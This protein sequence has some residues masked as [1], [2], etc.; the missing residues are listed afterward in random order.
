MKIKRICCVLI[1]ALLLMSVFPAVASAENGMPQHIPRIVS[2]VFDDSGSMYA[3]VSRWA[4]CSYAMQSFCAMMDETDELYV[5]Y[6][7]GRSDTQTVRLNKSTKQAEIDKFASLPFGGG[8]P[9]KVQAAADVLTDRYRRYGSEAKYF[10]LV[11]ADGELDDKT[12]TLRAEISKTAALTTQTIPASEFT[13]EFFDMS[14]YGGENA[15]ASES[16][17]SEKLRNICA[18]ITGRD[19]VDFRLDNGK[20]TFSIPYPAFSIVVFAQTYGSTISAGSVSAK[21]PD[22]KNVSGISSFSVK[23]PTQINRRPDFQEAVPDNP[24]SGVVSILKNGSAPLAKGSYTV[25]LSAAGLKKENVVVLIEPAVCIG[26]KYFIGEDK[27]PYTFEEASGKLSVGDQLTVQ[28][29]LYE[30]N[31]DGSIG[32]EVPEN[33]LKCDYSAYINGEQLNSARSSLKNAF[34]LILQETHSNGE[35]KIEAR[36]EGFSPFVDRETFGEIRDKPAFDP[37]LLGK[38]I[39]IAVTRPVFNDLSK[40]GR[41]LE[42]PFIK[43]DASMLG[44]F[45]VESSWDALPSGSCDALGQTVRLNGLTLE[46]NVAP[47]QNVTFADFPDTVT[48]TLRQT[49]TGEKLLTYT[50]KKQDSAFRIQVTE[51]PFEKQTLPPGAVKNNTQAIVFELQADYEGQGNYQS[52]VPD[53]SMNIVFTVD[54][55]ALPGRTG[56]DGTKATFTPLCTDEAKLSDL[57][58]KSFSVTAKAVVDGETVTSDSVTVSFAD[59]SYRLTAENGITGPMTLDQLKDN[60]LG[61]R[62]TVTA[63]YDGIGNYGPLAAWDTDVLERVTVTSETLP[64]LTALTENGVVFTPRYDENAPGGVVYTSIVARTHEIAAVI[65]GSDASASAQVEVSAPVFG[66][67][68]KKGELELLD[69]GLLK[70]KDG[71]AFT[72]T[73]DGRVLNAAEMEGLAPYDVRIEP[74]RWIGVNPIIVTEDD[75]SAYLLCIPIY[76]GCKL[77]TPKLWNWMSAVF[78][79][80]GDQTVTFSIGEN[81]AQATLTVNR[82]IIPIIILAVIGIL[83]IILAYVLYCVSSRERFQRGQFLV[84]HPEREWNGFS[85]SSPKHKRPK[86]I[87]GLQFVRAHRPMTCV[88]SV[89]DLRI[90]FKTQSGSKVS[91]PVALKPDSTENLY[92][93]TFPTQTEWLRL[94]SKDR[95]FNCSFSSFVGDDF[96]MDFTSRQGLIVQDQHMKNQYSLVIFIS[97]KELKRLHDDIKNIE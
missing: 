13:C 78:M 96:E 22:G 68:V 45:T 16:Q 3:G 54:S 17:I 50:F 19:E 77:F 24:P 58:N 7:N 81:S 62:F 95:N 14:S 87:Q 57:V 40:N 12:T 43:I 35:L 2:I 90:T 11:L 1:A 26:C 61:I 74:G 27:T 10:L 42:F 38:N 28:C 71:L 51:N 29:G 25:D 37:G 66:I 60:Q 92:V 31:P 86:R 39:E 47:D 70:N 94:L 67:Q 5:T 79:S 91:T 20:L 23:C 83:L 59:V 65:A 88:L 76:N 82:D 49:D 97:D 15:T 69:T 85:G 55:G 53:G 84:Y 64:G 41:K 36:I 72:V 44:G 63:D 33:V 93:C 32:A 48:V 30:V 75:G 9:C 4:Y 34:E 89:G 56:T 52:F 80:H 21:G 73:R 18:S 46:Y 6:L 8:T